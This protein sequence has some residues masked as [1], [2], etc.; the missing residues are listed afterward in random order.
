MEFQTLVALGFLRMKEQFKINL[1]GDEI[2]FEIFSGPKRTCF[3]ST[4]LYKAIT[5]FSI[6]MYVD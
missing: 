4:T 3:V 6:S 1:V 5:M 2:R